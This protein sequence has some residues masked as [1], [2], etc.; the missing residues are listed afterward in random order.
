MDS[1]NIGCVGSG[2]RRSRYTAGPLRRVVCARSVGAERR[3]YQSVFS[4]DVTATVTSRRTP[5]TSCAYQSGKVSLSPSVTSMPYGSTELSRSCAHS[6]VASRR[7]ATPGAS[8]RTAAR[9]RAASTGARQSSHAASRSPDLDARS[10]RASRH[11]AAEPERGPHAPGRVAPE[12]EVVAVAHLARD[13]RRA[14]GACDAPYLKF[15]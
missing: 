9:R 10:A 6:R 14:P 13:T 3:G 7:R 15:M 12:I 1:E 2:Q 4:S 5:S 11:S 8:C